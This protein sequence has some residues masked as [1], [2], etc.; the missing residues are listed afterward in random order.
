[1]L[2][3]RHS[4][5]ARLAITLR[6]SGD[7]GP[8]LAYIDGG[9]SGSGDRAQAP[10]ML[11]KYLKHIAAAPAARPNN[12]TRRTYRRRISRHKSRSWL[13]MRGIAT[14]LVSC[15]TGL[16]NV[17]GESVSL[18]QLI[19][20]LAEIAGYRPKVSHRPPRKGNS[21]SRP[22][23]RL[24]AERTRRDFCSRLRGRAKAAL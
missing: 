21:T 22:R 4:P 8:Y 11:G 10:L 6:K 19:D 14:A 18:L 1:M 13:M 16:C 12:N 20:T 15:F 5:C 17:G 7:G 2:E 3:W 9:P 23:S 24:A